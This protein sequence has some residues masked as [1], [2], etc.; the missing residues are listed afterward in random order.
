MHVLQWFRVVTLVVPGVF[1]SGVASAQAV[2]WSQPG[3][4]MQT[5][6]TTEVTVTYNRPV[7]R[8]RTL[9]GGIVAWGRIWNPG[10]DEATT[11]GLSEAVTFGGHEVAAGDYSV[12]IIPNENE[13]WTFILSHAS[14]VFHTPYPGEEHDALR[15]SVRPTT[16]DHME[17]LAF[18]FP[19][20]EPDGAVLRFHWG[21]TVIEFPMGVRTDP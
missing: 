12:W 11:I 8:G 2:R 6:A 21:T 15:M 13:P 9:F 14:D 18:Y 10:A 3:M 1:W 20:V 19:R 16:G 5:I 7:A 4:V 17:V